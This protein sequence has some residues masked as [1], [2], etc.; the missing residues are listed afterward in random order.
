VGYVAGWA[1]FTPAHQDITMPNWYASEKPLTTRGTG[2]ADVATLRTA[3]LAPHL[4]P[5]VAGSRLA[6]GARRATD[7]QRREDVRLRRWQRSARRRRRRTARFAYGQ[8]VTGDI[9]P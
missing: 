4:L 2:H 6:Y 8:A 3:P 5:D 7:Q 9:N 1:L